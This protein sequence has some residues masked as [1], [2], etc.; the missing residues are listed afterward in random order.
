MTS[1][2]FMISPACPARY[3]RH[4]DI[5]LG[6]CRT[7]VELGAGLAAD[8]DWGPWVAAGVTPESSMVR[9]LQLVGT[10]EPREPRAPFRI[11]QLLFHSLARRLVGGRLGGRNL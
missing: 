10:V 5:E 4:G 2:V 1:C 7:G 6:R 9:R 11:F 8:L 3:L